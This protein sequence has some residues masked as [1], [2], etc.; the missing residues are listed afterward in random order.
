[1]AGLVLIIMALLAPDTFVSQALRLSVA[2]FVLRFRYVVSYLTDLFSTI[3]CRNRS[4]SQA[5]AKVQTTVM[6]EAA[7]ATRSQNIGERSFRHLKAV[8]AVLSSL[9]AQIRDHSKAV[10]YLSSSMELHV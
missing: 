2:I 5:G 10:E 7:L 9:R 6:M 4:L 3:E 1:M 8:Y